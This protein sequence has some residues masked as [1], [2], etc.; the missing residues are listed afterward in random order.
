MTDLQ[1]PLTPPPA[2]SPLW[3]RILLALSLTLNLAVLGI[4]AGALLRDHDERR[5]MPVRDLGFGAFDD[6]LSPDDRRELRRAFMDE[7]PD[8][9]GARRAMRQDFAAIL[10]ALRADP[11]DPAALQTVLDRQNARGAEMLAFGQKLLSERVAAMDP[12]AR[13]AFADRLEESLTRKRGPGGR[14]HRRGPDEPGEN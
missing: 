8:F 10:T 4:V 9:R 2:R 13:L 5:P 3:M 11:F 7:G 14:E 12:A 6:A 1:P